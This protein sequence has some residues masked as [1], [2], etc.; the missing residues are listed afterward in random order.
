MFPWSMQEETPELISKLLAAF[1]P[2][3]LNFSL[4]MDH[5]RSLKRFRI[6]KSGVET[7]PLCLTFYK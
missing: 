3:F 5:L 2:C 1:E 7:E 4:Y 6:S